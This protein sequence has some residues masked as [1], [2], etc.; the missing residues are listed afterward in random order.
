M[1]EIDILLSALFS[2]IIVQSLKVQAEKLL[3]LD[4]PRRELLL[5]NCCITITGGSVTEWLGRRT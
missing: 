4:W 1:A 5:R 2:I 3:K